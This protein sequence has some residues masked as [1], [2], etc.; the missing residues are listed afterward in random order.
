MSTTY[1]R[2]CNLCEAICGLEITVAE[3]RVTDIR[4]DRSDPL[5]R[6]RMVA[7]LLLWPS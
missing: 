6:G 1:Y 4:G 2:A 3:G 7:F 5:G